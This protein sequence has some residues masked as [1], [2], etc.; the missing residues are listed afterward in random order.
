[1]PERRPGKW[2]SR[3]SLRAWWRSSRARLLELWVIGAL[4]SV[5]VTL[6]SLLGYLDGAQARN[7]DILMRLRGGAPVADVV[8]VAIDDEAFAALGER[9]PLPRDYLARVIRGIRRAGARVVGLDV[10]LATP[11]S[12]TA[13]FAL[14][15]AMLEFGDD[16][17]SRVVVV[18]PG[19][20]AT[21]PLADPGLDGRIVV[22]APDIAE[23]EDGVIRRAPLAVRRGDTV[24]PTFALAVAS[25]LQGLGPADLERSLGQAESRIVL[26]SWRSGEVAAPPG[27]AS[28]LVVRPD[29]LWRINFVGP[30]RTFL[31]LPSDAIARLADE[32]VTIA[33]D[34]PLRD[35]IVLIGGTFQESR[36]SYPTPHGRLSGV[37]IHANVIHMLGTRS[38]IK[39]SGWLFALGLQLVLVLATGVLLVL[40]S[41]LVGVVAA[42]GGAF[43]LGL[44]ASYLVFAR[45]HYS[46]DFMLPVLAMRVMAWGV[47]VLDRPGLRAR[48]WRYLKLGGADVGG[49]AVAGG[50][51]GEVAVLSVVLRGLEGRRAEGVLPSEVASCL[52]VFREVVAEAVGRHDGR[53]DAVGPGDRAGAVFAPSGAMGD[54]AARAVRAAVAIEEAVRALNSRWEAEGREPLSV[55]MGVHTMI[56]PDVDAPTLAVVGAAAEAASATERLGDKLGS[57]ILLT[58]TTRRALGDAVAV[59]ERGSVPGP[60]EGE[61]LT[62]YELITLGA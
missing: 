32:S 28:S 4:A 23:D 18:E 24:M 21:G 27:G 16:E 49:A 42:L 26:R 48:L 6:A 54:H 10:D 14:I 41:P 61:E 22:G 34:N 40:V 52:P 20:R 51:R 35:R 29:E 44:P 8:I 33:H 38:F 25:R 56:L 11:T 50:Q 1:M 39:P 31:M 13:D 47:D 46:I 3:A 15:E 12:A 60:S 19:R 53:L 7:L 9:Q 43:V 30:A 37:E 36:D 62:V 58:E 2:W 57:A 45:G 5:G 59:V 17:V 55:G